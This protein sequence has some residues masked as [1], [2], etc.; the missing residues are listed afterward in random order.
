MKYTDESRNWKQRNGYGRGYGNGNRNQQRKAHGGLLLKFKHTT[1]PQRE[2][3]PIKTHNLE[4]LVVDWEM[5]MGMVKI[6]MI[7]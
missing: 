2:E 7:K 4:E 5:V 1:P 3:S 6:G